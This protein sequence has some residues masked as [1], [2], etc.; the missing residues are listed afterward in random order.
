MGLSPRGR[1]NLEVDSVRGAR[2]RSIPAW[3]GKPLP[4]NI[5]APRNRKQVYPRVG[6]GNPAL[7]RRPIRILLPAVYP[8]VGGETQDHASHRIAG[9][10]WQVYPRVGGETL[11]EIGWWPDMVGLSPRETLCEPRSADIHRVYPRVGGETLTMPTRNHAVYPRVGATSCRNSTARVY[12][13]VGGET[14]CA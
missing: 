11:D 10:A 8:R 6:G 14:L 13:R 7:R 5:N 4:L 12:P 1:G 9:A 3:A 2:L